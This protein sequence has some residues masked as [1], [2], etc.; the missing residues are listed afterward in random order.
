[1]SI[2][3]RSGHERTIR[4]NGELWTRYPDN[5]GDYG[6]ADLQAGLS[7]PLAATMFLRGLRIAEIGAG[8]AVS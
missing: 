1:M 4:D 7:G 6:S 5:G 3:A 2:T 8:P